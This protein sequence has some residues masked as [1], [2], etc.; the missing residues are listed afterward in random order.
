MTTKSVLISGAGIAGSTAAFWLARTGWEVTVVEKA[1]SIRSSGNPIDVRG[2]AAAVVHGMGV[3][4]T[5]RAAATSVERLVVVD[6]AGRPKIT[7]DTRNTTDPDREVEVPRADLAATLL[8]AARDHAEVVIGD[9]ITGLGQ[10]ASGVDVEFDRAAPR[11]FDLVL[12]ADGLHSGVRRLAFGAEKD[13]SSPFGMFVGT[14]H[15]RLDTP[16]P[17]E[18]RLYNQP[19]VSLSIHPGTGDPLAAFI[20]RSDEQYDH[21]DKDARKRMIREA[22]AGRG[23]VSDLAVAEWDAADDVY[24]DA[25]TRITMPTW[26]KNRVTL[27]GDA[28]DCISLLGEGS[29]NAIVAA[30]TLADALAEYPDDQNAALAAY[31]AT[32]RA[33]LRTFQRQAGAN[34]RFLVPSTALGLAVRNASMRVTSLVHKASK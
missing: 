25:V 30:K 16:D 10:D 5:L 13:F 26:T 20:F 7:I 9:S 11:R 15:T 22:Y 2:D 4:P 34:S 14:M 6:G 29:S 8:G 19:G 33:R 28:A 32:H 24:F 17:H 23:W 3:W 21:H 12:G 31:E 18:L 1:D 27:L